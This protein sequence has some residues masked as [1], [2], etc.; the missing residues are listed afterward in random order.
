MIERFA[1]QRQSGR[2][3]TRQAHIN[4]MRSQRGGDKRRKGERGFVCFSRPLS[5]D[6]GLAVCALRA[7][8]N[9]LTATNMP[10][11]SLEY[12]PMPQWV[13]TCAQCHKIFTHSKINPRTATSPFDPLWPT[14]PDF[15]DGGLNLA[16]PKCQTP[17][18]YQR[19]ELMYR[20][21]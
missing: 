20:P 15:P 4:M 11:G 2:V 5:R 14:K 13:L 3:H 10:P 6:T 9:R 19:F 8:N 21:N 7:A 16:C 12:I 18:I 17:A 1:D